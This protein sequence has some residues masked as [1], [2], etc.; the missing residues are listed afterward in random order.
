MA[1]DEQLPRKRARAIA[2]GDLE[3]HEVDARDVEGVDEFLH[4]G[5]AHEGCLIVEILIHDGL[6]EETERLGGRGAAGVC[7]L[8]KVAGDAR[9]AFRRGLLVCGRLDR[10]LHVGR[11]RLEQ[12]L[13]RL[14][15]LQDGFGGLTYVEQLA[16]IVQLRVQG[17]SQPHRRG[18]AFFGCDCRT[19]P[20][21]PTRPLTVR[22]AFDDEAGIL[23]K[24][25]LDERSYCRPTN[26]GRRCRE[27]VPH[28]V[29]AART[30]NGIRVDHAGE[31]PTQQQ[32]TSWSGGRRASGH[33]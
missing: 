7:N 33:D 11:G 24:L 9:G 14:A 10:F 30:S 13:S 31:E 19:V 18:T 15:G 23:R 26:D 22:K 12:R 32:I 1:V 28:N 16:R 8:P 4:R 21:E 6:G 5:N 29:S 3:R 25:V 20:C 2:L 27:V 17:S